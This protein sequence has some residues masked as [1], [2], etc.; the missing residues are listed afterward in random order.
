MR[1]NL[2]WLRCRVMHRD[3]NYTVVRDWP[4]SLA[5]ICN[6][7]GRARATGVATWHHFNGNRGPAPVDNGGLDGT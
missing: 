2:K 5:V 6:V 1:E 4:S 3:F 7:C